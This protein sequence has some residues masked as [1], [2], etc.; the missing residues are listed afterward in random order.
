M[1]IVIEAMISPDRRLTDYELPP[2]APVG[3]VRLLIQPAQRENSQQPS[4]TREEARAR[5]LAGG[6][7]NT[8]YRAPEDAVLLPDDQLQRLAQPGHRSLDQLL[9]DD[10]RPR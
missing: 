8:S 2:D 9:D 5:L 7:L 10:R 1:D 3:R 6:A 4:L